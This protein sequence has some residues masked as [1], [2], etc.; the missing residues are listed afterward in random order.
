MKE[1]PMQKENLNVK[2]LI[3]PKKTQEI[4]NPKTDNQ[5]RRN[6]NKQNEKNRQTLLTAISQDQ[7]S[8]LHNQTIFQTNRHKKEAA[9]VT[10]IADK[11]DFKPKTIRRDGKDTMS[12]SRSNINEPN[13]R[14]SM[15]RKEQYNSL[16]HML[17]LTH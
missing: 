13:P 10:F 8:E 14:A 15:F 2:R 5:E 6:S 16:N 17:I 1:K 11:R 12:P 4:H 9:V 3:T 7:W